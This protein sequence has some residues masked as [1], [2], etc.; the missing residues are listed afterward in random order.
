MILITRHGETEWNAVG[1]MQG[2]QNSPLTEQGRKQARKLARV[3]ETYSMERLIVSPLGRARKTGVI[4]ADYN[5]IPLETDDRLKEIDIGRYTG[6][7]KKEVKERN[8]DFF[9]YREENKWRYSW[10]EGESYEDASERVQKFI[11]DIEDLRDSVILGHRSVN[12][13]LLGQLLDLSEEK[14]L[15][16]EQ[17]ND[18]LFEVKPEINFEKRRYD[19]ILQ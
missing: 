14:I 1:K 10:P 9:S 11:S 2:R 12:R 5:D 7:T 4:V 16:I 8:P 18:A 17:E 13:V 15:N 19:D 3:V 6:L